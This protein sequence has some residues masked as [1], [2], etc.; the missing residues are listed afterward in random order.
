MSSL[1]VVRCDEGVMYLMS[2]R[3]PADIGLQFGKASY[4][5]SR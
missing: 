3:H 5:R 4:P 2:P 1:E